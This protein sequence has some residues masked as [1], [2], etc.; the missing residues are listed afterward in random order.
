MKFAEWFAPDGAPRLLAAL[1]VVAVV[2]ASGAPP[3]RAAEQEEHYSKTVPASEHVRVL[4]TNRSGDT[5]IQSWDRAEVQVD[6]VKRA[7]ARNDDRARES[8]QALSVEIDAKD[9]EV[10]VK[11][12]YPEHD[13]GA[14]TVVGLLFG[15]HQSATIDLTLHVP[16]GA[17]VGASSTSGDIKVRDVAGPVQVD[18]TSGDVSVGSVTDEVSVDCTSGDVEIGNVTGAVHVRSTSGDVKSTR[19]AAAP[20]STRRA[21]T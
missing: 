8:L 20:T 7:R 16:R 13:Q 6:V 19:S 21:A 2:T 15:D 14:K 17:R 3:A 1:A 4:V 9:A 5:D 10:S 18:C 12:H 11:A